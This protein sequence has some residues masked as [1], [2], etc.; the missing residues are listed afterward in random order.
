[1]L[2]R[3]NT[4]RRCELNEKLL[5][6]WI[7]FIELRLGTKWY[8]S[9]TFDTGMY[10]YSP[11]GLL[12]EHHRTTPRGEATLRQ[13]S[14]RQEVVSVA[15]VTVGTNIKGF[16]DRRIKEAHQREYW[17]LSANIEVCIRILEWIGRLQWDMTYIKWWMN[18]GLTSY[19]TRSQKWIRR[20]RWE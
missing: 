5:G 13:S 18:L 4:H 9:V 14:D 17:R 8:Q 10:C 6:I 19:I 2:T 15:G 12:I 20:P 7:N 1:M 3:I 16:M 11:Y